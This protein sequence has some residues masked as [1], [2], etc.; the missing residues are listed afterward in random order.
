MDREPKR[1][2]ET[3]KRESPV[4]TPTLN[5]ANQPKVNNPASQA[6]GNSLSSQAKS[7]KPPS[8]TNGNNFLKQPPGK[9][10]A[11]QANGN[12]SSASVHTAIT[13]FHTTPTPTER[14][15]VQVTEICTIS[16]HS[17]TFFFTVQRISHTTSHMFSLSSGPPLSLSLSQPP[18]SLS[19]ILPSPYTS[20]SL[21]GVPPSPDCEICCD[22]WPPVR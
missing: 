5:P 21:L 16:P 20:Y 1:Q 12:Q 17:V 9:I 22:T 4:Q 15:V 10:L 2:S 19:L 8:Q 18:P 11:S 7:N 13:T 6:N 14:K 3:E